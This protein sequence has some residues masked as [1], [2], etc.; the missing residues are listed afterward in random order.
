M[1]GRLP[2]RSRGVSTRK[3]EIFRGSSPQRELA[4]AKQIPE[5]GARFG[6]KNRV[7]LV[8]GGCSQLAFF[9]GTF[10]PFLRASE[11]PI[12][13]ACLRLVTLPPLPPLPERSVPSFSRRMALST[14][15]PAALPYFVRP[16]F[17]REL[18][19]F[20]DVIESLLSLRGRAS[21]TG[22]RD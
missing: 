4:G 11:R 3:H 20:P 17:L 18:E 21:P 15:L 1:L 8:G 19:L 22:C 5:I 12:A 2:S 14:L 13:M 10:A 9:S 16:D 7:A 6:P